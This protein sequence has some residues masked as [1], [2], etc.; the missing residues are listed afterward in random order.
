MEIGVRVEAENLRTGKVR[1]SASA[2]LT[3]VALGE[4]HR[5]TQIPPII[6]ETEE[7]LRRNCEAKLRREARLEAESKAKNCCS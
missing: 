5:P 7:D 6:L 3:Y 2:Y 1:W 4:D